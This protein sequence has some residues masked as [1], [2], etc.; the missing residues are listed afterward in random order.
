MPPTPVVRDHR[1]GGNGSQVTVTNPRHESGVLDTVGGA[2]K[3]AGKAI[4]TVGSPTP[5]TAGAGGGSTST[6]TQY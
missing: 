4:I 2:I 1:P 5:G 3:D 6:K